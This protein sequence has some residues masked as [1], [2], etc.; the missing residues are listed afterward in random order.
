[1]VKLY[2]R[3][4]V[5]GD[6]EMARRLQ[7]QFQDEVVNYASAQP[8]SEIEAVLTPST[9]TRETSHLALEGAPLARPSRQSARS[10]GHVTPA[11]KKLNIGRATP[12]TETS[13]P[14]PERHGGSDPHSWI[15]DLRV[16]EERRSRR[17]TT[18]RS[19]PRGSPR[20]SPRSSPKNSI[21]V[22][23]AI[24]TYVDTEEDET[25]ARRLDQELRDAEL[26][27]RLER[28]ER[29]KLNRQASA[30]FAVDST[31]ARTVRSRDSF[32]DSPS[33]RRARRDARPTTLR[34]K[35]LYYGLRVTSGVLVLGV[36]F[37]IWITVFGSQASD[38]L[39]PTTWL[40]GWPDE[41]PMLGSVGDHNVWKT[42]GRSGL[43][44]P[45]LNNLDSN[46]NWRRLLKASIQQ[47]N[48]G[49]PKA[50]DINIREMTYDPD[51][52]AVR[53]AMKVCN[54][55]YGPTNW[56]GVNQILLQDD[57]IIT[58]LAKMN[59]YYLEGTN[60]AQKLYT[61]CHELGH[62]LGLGHSDENFH[63]RDLGN[64]MDY[65]ER[66]ERNMHP[67]ESNFETLVDMYG[68]LGG[69]SVA[70][71]LPSKSGDDRVLAVNVDADRVEDFEKYAL[72]LQEPIVA[73][74]NVDGLRH[75]GRWRLLRDSGGTEHY[76]RDLGE[77]YK[78]L[79]TFMLA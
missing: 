3:D 38:Q 45:V 56:R 20:G 79:A 18:P 19:S 17:S 41:D 71:Q 64:C 40:P 50:V 16:S 4:N 49:I 52:R 59:D 70:Q 47:W 66:P 53:K 39:D 60:R 14:S 5:D 30:A 57:Y 34:G 75:D 15:N 13:T 63:N 43:T 37:L 55:N 35:F 33:P 51:C 23:Q 74:S 28:E 65:T 25:L 76:E 22:P 21:S 27:S 11:E 10:E 73:D 69:V 58:S 78:M 12:D 7:E 42:K 36:T 67:D 44:L 61:M 77:G 26:A 9:T 6:E 2:A 68:P 62:G 32:A 46:S 8:R 48:D 72:F 31:P 54:G 29:T 24:G 1:M